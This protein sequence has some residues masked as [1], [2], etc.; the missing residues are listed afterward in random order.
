[1]NR[2]AQYLDQPADPFENETP[3]QLIAGMAGAA[4]HAYREMILRASCGEPIDRKTIL[5]IASNAGKSP[6]A[7][8]A[9]LQNAQAAYFNWQHSVR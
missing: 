9:D 4:T 6:A 1:M 8:L 7:M 5:H 2:I 3:A